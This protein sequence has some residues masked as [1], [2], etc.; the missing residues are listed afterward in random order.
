[1]NKY[2]LM[3]KCLAVAIIVLLGLN[4]A[5]LANGFSQEKLM[6][7][8][9]LNPVSISV[10]R[11]I[12]ITLDGYKGW[13]DWY[14]SNVKVWISSDG[15]HTYYK[16]NNDSWT[17]NTPGTPIIVTIDGYYNLSAYCVYENGT[18]SPIVSASFKIDKT[19]PMINEFNFKRIG[20]LKWKFTA[21][22]Y[23]AMSGINSVMFI[24]N[25]EIITNLTSPPYEYSI[26]VGLGFMF[27]I[28]WKFRRTGDWEYL[29]S[30][31]TYDNAGNSPIRP[32]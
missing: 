9:K 16:I 20:I 32:Q 31:L 5:P 12:N 13:N 21:D 3:R 29:P 8:E 22:V 2:L 28:H 10:S 7:N 30:C 15:N 14:A 6:V 26:K 11:D 23:D 1:M 27:M 17:E 4:L 24:I 19:A 18:Q 25:C